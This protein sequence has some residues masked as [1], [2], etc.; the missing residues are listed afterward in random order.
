MSV[1][2]PSYEPRVFDPAMLGDALADIAKRN[3]GHPV[4]TYYGYPEGPK[5]RGALDVV[6]EV[7]A[8]TE[9]THVIPIDLE[10]LPKSSLLTSDGDQQPPSAILALLADANLLPKD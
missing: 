9:I 10:R 4:V 5:I 6:A 7:E 1:L 2:P 3:A 8:G